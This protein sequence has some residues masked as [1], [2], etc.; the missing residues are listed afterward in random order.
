M[1]TA[2]VLGLD[3]EAGFGGAEV[4]D[5]VPPPL[6]VVHTQ[7]DNE[8]LA[9]I[10]ALEAKGAGS[11]TATH[12]KNVLIIHFG[13]GAAISIVEA[14]LLDDFEEGIGVGLVDADG[15]VVTH[16]VE[17]PVMSTDSLI[18]VMEQTW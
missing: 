9:G 18:K 11:T 3:Q 4:R 12:G 1:I 15:D 7:G 14:G 6:V 5:D 8:S 13:P 16:S 2:V 10:V 17:S